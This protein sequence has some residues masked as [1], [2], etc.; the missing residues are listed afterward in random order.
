V[1]AVGFVVWAYGARIDSSPTRVAGMIVIAVAVALRLLPATLR[2][3]IDGR[4][5]DGDRSRP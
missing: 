4:A 3:R 2:D 5:M 1:A